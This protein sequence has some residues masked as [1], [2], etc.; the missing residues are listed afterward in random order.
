VAVQTN[1]EILIAGQYGTIN[2]LGWNSPALLRTDGSL[3]TSFDTNGAG[4]NGSVSKAILQADGKILI[5]GNFS[6]FDGTNYNDIARLNTNGALDATFNPGT[7]PNGNVNALG[8]QSSGQIILGGTFT[9]VNNNN[10]NYL[11]RLNTGG[12]VDT[13]FNALIQDTNT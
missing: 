5:S 2:G 10:L 9:S 8:L 1:G 3:D 4:T 7:G 6:A 12:S 13:S 11:A